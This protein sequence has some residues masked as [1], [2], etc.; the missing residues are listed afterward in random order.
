MTCLKWQNPALWCPTLV[1]TV[2]ILTLHFHIDSAWAC[3]ASAMSAE[4]SLVKDCWFVKTKNFSLGKQKKKKKKGVWQEENL[5]FE[6]LPEQLDQSGWRL[7]LEEQ[8]MTLLS[9]SQKQE[10]EPFLPHHRWEEA[11]CW[12]VSSIDT[13]TLESN[14]S[15]SRRKRTLPC[16]APLW[17][18]VGAADPAYRPK[19][20]G[21][22]QL[23]PLPGGC[24][25]LC[26]S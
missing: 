19:S 5:Q 23:L 1:L 7:S 26:Y 11:L 12:W 17:H 10:I 18:S 6:V 3:S 2:D 25:H 4:K 9:S 8:S 15:P 16:L 24:R 22:G 20:F 14:F 13:G 21:L